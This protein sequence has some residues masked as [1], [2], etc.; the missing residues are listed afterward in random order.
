MPLIDLNLEGLR[1]YPGRNP[2]PAD[3]DTFWDGGLAELKGLGSSLTR[4]EAAFK[5]ATAHTEDWFFSGIGGARIYARAAIPK[6]AGPH[7]VVLLFHG[8]TSRVADWMT[9]GSWVAAGFAAVALDCRGQSGLSEDVGGVKG[10]TTHGNV[11]RGLLGAPHELYYRQVF[12]DCA[13][14]A[15]Y[16]FDQPEFDPQRVSCHGASQGG[17]LAL[18]AAALEPRITACAPVYPYL[19]DYQRVWEMDLA[20]D[21]YS[22]LRTFFRTHDPRHE[23]LDHWFT[24]L[25][26]IDVQY[27]A[28]RIRGRVQMATGLMDTITPPSSQFAAFNRIT[29]PKKV[30]IYPD[31]GHEGL[32]EI[33]ELSV[34][35]FSENSPPP[36]A[37]LAD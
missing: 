34:T 10:N 33:G 22:D 32:P 18:V 16:L 7:P 29:A 21:A 14:L 4:S 9:L 35:F 20:K 1:E 31:F 24:K 27:L 15:G 13:Q 5:L 28:P 2:R 37:R 30:V 25:G 6:T 12:L 23:R 8:Y 26:Y 3:F 36:D 17:A 19:C 11:T